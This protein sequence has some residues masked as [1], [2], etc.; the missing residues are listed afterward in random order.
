MQIPAQRIRI[1]SEAL[2]ELKELIE[3]GEL[4]YGKYVGAFEK[5]WAQMCG[6]KYAIALNSCTS[7][8]EVAL[9]ALNLPKDKF[10]LL[11]ANTYGATLQAVW[12]AGLKPR[13]QDCE[14]DLNM[15]MDNIDWKDISAVI[16]VYIGGNVPERMGDFVWQC[17]WRNIPLIIDAAHAHGSNIRNYGDILCYSFY[18]TKLI[19]TFGEGGAIVTDLEH[20]DNFARR[21]RHHGRISSGMTWDHVG[22]GANM[23]MTEAQAVVGL[24][25]IARLDKYIRVRKKVARVYAG[26]WEPIFNDGNY[27][28]YIIPFTPKALKVH[29]D[30]TLPSPVY[31]KPLH[32][33]GFWK[34]DKNFPNADFY[35]LNHTCL[36]IYN[37]MTEDEA[38]HVL[39]NVGEAA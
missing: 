13:L 6:R 32:R 11:P 23:C 4:A 15:S 3:T 27:Y 7:S 31:P 30:I 1:D 29:P 9:R 18:A 21:Y 38:K 20:V 14:P 2:S 33:H 39:E 24:H 34:G 17:K 37:D 8:L 19:T 16:M 26:K 12:N 25:E 5:Q 36:P 10:V 28:K 22:P 35:C